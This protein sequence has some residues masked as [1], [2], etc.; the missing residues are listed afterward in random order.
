M[1]ACSYAKSPSTLD[2]LVCATRLKIQRSVR[3]KRRAPK[4][5]STP[6][7][8]VIRPVTQTNLSKP[9]DTSCTTTRPHPTR[10]ANGRFFST[11]S[12][13]YALQAHQTLYTRSP[14]AGIA[15]LVE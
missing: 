1:G 11:E 7:F 6:E 8:N 4:A 10:G 14:L 2:P 9:K 5:K 15:Q 13:S 3:H 12:D